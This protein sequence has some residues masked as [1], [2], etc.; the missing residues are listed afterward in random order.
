MSELIHHT[1]LG[2][3]P[4]CQNKLGMAHSELATW[5]NCIVKIAYP[6]AH[7]SWSYRDQADQEQCF[8]DG[9]T[10]LHFPNSAHN[11]TPALALDLFQIDDHGEGVWSPKFFSDVKKL[12]PSHIVWGGLWKTLGD[13]DHFELLPDPKE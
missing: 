5:F 9:K 4:S 1:N 7:V 6:N 8:L 12:T 13:N 10:R 2:P 11:K 3:C